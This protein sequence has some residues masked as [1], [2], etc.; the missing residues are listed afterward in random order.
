MPHRWMHRHTM[1]RARAGGIPR[2][3]SRVRNAAAG[4]IAQAWRGSRF[5]SA[6]WQRQ[7]LRQVLSHTYGHR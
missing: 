5:R 1:Q 3:H 6:I 4:R 7:R 2:T